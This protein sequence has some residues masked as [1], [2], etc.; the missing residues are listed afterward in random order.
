[1]S[2]VWQNAPHSGGELLTLLAIADFADD[3]GVAWPSVA[4]I[5]KKTRLSPRQ[6]NRVIVELKNTGWLTVVHGS[7]RHKSNR[8]YSGNIVVA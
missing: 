7:G 2:Q 8:V 6:V 3:A 4:V 1:M 5:A